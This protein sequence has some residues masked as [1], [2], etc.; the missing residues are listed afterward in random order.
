VEVDEV[1]KL[2]WSLR[3]CWRFHLKASLSSKSGLRRGSPASGIEDVIGRPDL[4]D[5]A[6]FLTLGLIREEQRRSESELWREFELARPA[7]LGALLD[8]A[9]EG[10]EAMG[11]VLLGPAA[12]N[13]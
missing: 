3:G 8:A 13:G 9:V 1:A 12:A 5:R 7:I 11:S 10:L 6:I 2:I 4:A